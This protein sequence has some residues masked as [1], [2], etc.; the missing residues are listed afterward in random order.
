MA[1]M[2][3]RTSV[4]R[5][6]ILRQFGDAVRQLRGARGWSQEDLAERCGLDRTYL[7]GVERGER[8]VG[9]INLV[10]IAVALD[11]D[12]SKLVAGLGR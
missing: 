3:H 11:V 6:A 5:G 12:P 8:N 2:T 4:S 9:L 1:E 7:G 10:R